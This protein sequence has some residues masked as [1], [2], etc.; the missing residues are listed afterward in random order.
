MTSALSEVPQ[1]SP[2]LLAARGI[3]KSFDGVRVLHGIDFELRQ[4]EVHGFIGQNGAGKSTMVKILSGAYT[5]DEGV[6]EIDG[7]P[8][9][10]VGSTRSRPGIAMVFQ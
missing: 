6:I 10:S 4:G 3:Q 2:V 5:A 1:V 8:V 7:S 9:A